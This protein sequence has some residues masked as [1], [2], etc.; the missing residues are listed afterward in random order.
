MPLHGYS[1]DR[2]PPTNLDHMRAHPYALAVAAWQI[3]VGGLVL[4]ALVFNF[5]FTSSAMRLPRGPLFALCLVLILGAINVMRG[6]FDDSNDLRKGF[7]IERGGLI[8]SGAGWTSFSVAVFI[9]APGA[10]P[11]W[12]MGV[13]FS[14]AMALRIDAG[15]REENRIARDAKDLNT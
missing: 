5:H 15:I 2:R 13:L 1:T 11:T 9:G 14:I 8:L 4:V 12:S 3:L 10:V 7:R 6:L